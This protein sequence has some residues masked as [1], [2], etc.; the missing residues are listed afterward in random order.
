MT[1]EKAI[2]ELIKTYEHANALDY[3]IDPVAH[4]LYQ[5]WKEADR[6]RQMKQFDKS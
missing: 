3:I 1:I 4:A 2:R 5:V 6:D